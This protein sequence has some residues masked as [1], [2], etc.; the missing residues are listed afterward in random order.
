ML[1][2]AFL[3]ALLLA[4]LCSIIIDSLRELSYYVCDMRKT[5]LFLSFLLVVLLL[6]SSFFW[7]YEARYLVGR[8]STI[9]SSFSLDNSYVFIS[10]LR[11]K[12]DSQE[13]IRLTVFVLSGQGIGVQ[14]KRVV[15]AIAPALTIETIQGITDEYGKAV[16]D[17]TSSDPGEFYIDIL[18]EGQKLKQQAHLLYY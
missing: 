4:K 13:K 8:A 18:I 10:P 3:I 6:F 17:I 12:A 15:P 2:P 7:L 11:A 5:L 1:R 9:Q 14:G 16:F